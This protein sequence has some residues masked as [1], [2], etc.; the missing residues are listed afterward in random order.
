MKKLEYSTYTTNFLNG[1]NLDEYLFLFW[2]GFSSKIKILII[3]AI[4]PPNLLGILR[5][6]AYANKKYH[7][8]WMW[9]GVTIGLA[10]MKFSGSF[11]I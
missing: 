5:K 10:E 8:G 2:N 9:I 1:L 11:E 3:S 7:S 6:I 4:T